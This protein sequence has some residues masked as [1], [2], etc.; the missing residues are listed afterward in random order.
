MPAQVMSSPSISITDTEPSMPVHLVAA[1]NKASLQFMIIGKMGFEDHNVEKNN[2]SKY[3][4]EFLAALGHFVII[5]TTNWAGDPG[6]FPFGDFSCSYAMNSFIVTTDA[7]FLP[8]MM[9]ASALRVTIQSGVYITLQAMDR[10][11]Q[12]KSKI[13]H[14]SSMMWAHVT[15]PNALDPTSIIV[16]TIQKEFAKAGLDVPDAKAQFG[17]IGQALD[18]YHADFVINR[19]TGIVPDGMMRLK[20]IKLPSEVFAYTASP[21]SSSRSTRSRIA[22][23]RCPTSTAPSTRTR[24]APARPPRRRC[25]SATSARCRTRHVAASWTSRRAA[26]DRLLA[27]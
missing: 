5:H 4:N 22:A 2:D 25:A 8:V 17:D 23:L 16:Q 24:T 18:R 15:A 27:L 1:G 11:F 20:S 10:E 26:T 6:N 12:A 21:G 14:I 3:R 13:Q 9:Q 19:V 7:S